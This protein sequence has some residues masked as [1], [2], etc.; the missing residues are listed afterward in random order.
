M[1][2][3][4][5]DRMHGSGPQR[6][7]TL[8][9]AARAFGLSFALAAVAGLGWAGC[10]REGHIGNAD[11]GTPEPAERIERYEIDLF[12]FGRQLG[13]IAPCG[14]TTE[15]LGGLQFAFGYIDA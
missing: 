6:T 3:N 5:S 8:D 10:N 7:L 4:M 2:V 1:A 12:A 15:P 11:S 13:T 14:C 9:M